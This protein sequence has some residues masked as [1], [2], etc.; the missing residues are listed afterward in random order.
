MCC[1]GDAG[2]YHSRPHIWLFSLLTEVCVT[3]HGAAWAHKWMCHAMLFISFVICIFLCWCDDS[4]LRWESGMP[5]VAAHSWWC[6]SRTA[7]S[8]WCYRLTPI[9][10]SS[11]FL[12]SL[13]SLSPLRL[14]DINTGSLPEPSHQ[15]PDVQSKCSCFRGFDAPPSWSW[16]LPLCSLISRQTQSY[17]TA[18]HRDDTHP[19]SSS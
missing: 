18:R 4:M 12:C 5:G 16:A 17:F 6:K 10:M 1:R 2:I 3:P 7:V 11:S 15:W 8:Y 19:G 13:L 14:C 9:R